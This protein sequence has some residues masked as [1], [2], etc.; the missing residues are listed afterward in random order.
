MGSGIGSGMG[1]GM[2]NI[3]YLI[4]N[5]T[6]NTNHLLPSKPLTS[7]YIR[8]QVL[9]Q[10]TNNNNY[11]SLPIE[12]SSCRECMDYLNKRHISQPSK[13][14]ISLPNLDNNIT[15]SKK[16]TKNDT[17]NSWFILLLTFISIFL[18]ASLG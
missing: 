13:N 10:N 8:N 14:N 9:Q 12:N 17:E 3:P 18:I 11:I 7:D 6:E 4:N 2:S 5:N 15:Q 16:N 1:N